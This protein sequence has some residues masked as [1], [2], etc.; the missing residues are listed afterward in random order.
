MQNFQKIDQSR[1]GVK[2]TVYKSENGSVVQADCLC[3]GSP[4]RVHSHPNCPL[5]LK[6]LQEL[7][8]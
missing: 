5:R 2:V 8:K 7:K 6:I 4:N 3:Y 1:N